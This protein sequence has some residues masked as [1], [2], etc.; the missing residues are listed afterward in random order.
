[1]DAAMTETTSDPVV[2][3]AGEAP[4]ASAKAAKKE[5][6]F[7][8]FLIKL[9]VIVAIFRS[10]TMSHNIHHRAE[11]G[12]YLRPNDVP[13]PGLYVPSADEK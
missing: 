10:F 8:V 6:S 1:M 12:V 4:P 7:F 9:V 11:L 13:V 3:P 5:D 2:E